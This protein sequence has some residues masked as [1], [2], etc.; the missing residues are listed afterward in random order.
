MTGEERAALGAVLRALDDEPLSHTEIRRLMPEG[1]R[2]HVGSGL[3]LGLRAGLVT[4]ARFTN[5]E[6]I[7]CLTPAGAAQLDDEDKAMA[8]AAK[9]AKAS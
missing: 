1:T 8:E 3:G 4:V 5:C 9:K 6:T 2:K 7:Y